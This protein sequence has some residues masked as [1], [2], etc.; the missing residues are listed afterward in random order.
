MMEAA[1]S[2]APQKA[3]QRA[4]GTAARQQECVQPDTHAGKVQ[5]EHR[6]EPL[7]SGAEPT[8]RR[9]SGS[10]CCRLVVYLCV[11]HKHA[12]TF[13][14]GF[15]LSPDPLLLHTQHALIRADGVGC[16]SGGNP[17]RSQTSTVCPWNSFFFFFVNIVSKHL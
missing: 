10:P 2:A 16:L 17:S 15:C 14:P 4:R 8:A 9:L 6:Q 11:S 5:R 3:C 13:P 12:L 7:L 1:A